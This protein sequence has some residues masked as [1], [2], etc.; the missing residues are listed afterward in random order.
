VYIDGWLAARIEWNTDSWHWQPLIWTFITNYFTI[1]DSSGSNSIVLCLVG[2]Y[3]NMSTP[4]HTVTESDVIEIT[5]EVHHA[6]R[7]RTPVIQCLPETPTDVVSHHYSSRGTLRYRKVVTVT[8]RMSN[9]TFHCHL[10]FVAA[11]SNISNNYSPVRLWTSPVINIKC[12][13]RL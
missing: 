3:W 12:K 2:C 5:C 11:S 8:S 10:S 6:D 1:C 13:S 9:V 4:N 7:R